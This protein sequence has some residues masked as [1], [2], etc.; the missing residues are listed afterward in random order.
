MAKIAFVQ[1][2]AFEY[3]GIMHIS[4]V[5]KANGHNVEIFIGGNF[6][7]LANDI[8]SYGANLVGFSCHTGNYSWC[9]HAAEAIKNLN[10]VLT[11]FGGPHPTFFPE[12]ITSPH[13]DAVCQGEGE[14]ASLELADKFDKKEDITKIPNCWFK[15]NGQIIKNDL[16]PL[17]EDLDSIPFP[18]REM[19]Y[20][21]YPFL[22]ISL[23]SFMAG[24]GCPFKCSY[25]FNESMQQL[26]SHKGRY[27]RYR[28]VENVLEEIKSVYRKYGMRT[29]YMIDDTFILNK[30]WACEFLERYAKEIKLPLICLVRV[31]LL[32]EEIVKKLKNAN[33]RAVFFGIESG[34]EQL[35]NL[36][37]N[38][39]ITNRQIIE[40]AKLLKS[41]GIKYRT[42]N[43]MGIP[44]ET[45]DDAF[46]TIKI[47]STINTDYPWCSILQPYPK[48]KIEKYALAHSLF[49]S[50]Q[51]HISASFFHDT[52]LHFKQKRELL[53]LQKLF[54]FAVKFPRL[55]P[56]I[57]MLIKLPPNLFFDLAFQIG[58]ALSYWKSEN[59]K[60]KEFISLGLRNFRDL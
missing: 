33:C 32:N 5:L 42:Y 30:S 25:C 22:N 53:N 14:M 40:A 23:K 49:D 27:V 47:N 60:L 41:Y 19:Y 51:A 20:K 39:N 38:K 55:T 34:N 28:S 10:N 48:T 31:D 6:E 21:N 1:K 37:L 35:R 43:M 9:S 4:S 18:D 17:I 24:R 46:Q 12:I 50:G 2:L 11:V 16:R 36:V 8:K 52:I 59:L 56:L 13:I 29:V 57:K 54:F 58:Y 3:L 44:G 26:Y 45:L 15:Q 7:K